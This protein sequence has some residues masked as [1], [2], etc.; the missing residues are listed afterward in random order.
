M[1]AVRHIV[2]KGL[3][4]EEKDRKV[5]FMNDI[6]SVIIVDKKIREVLDANIFTININGNKSFRTVVYFITKKK[7][8]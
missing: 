3:L 4:T 1:L 8:Y 6:S 5:W 2:T 7:V